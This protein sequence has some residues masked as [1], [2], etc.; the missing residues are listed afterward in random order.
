MK[1]FCGAEINPAPRLPLCEPP[2]RRILRVAFLQVFESHR[3]QIQLRRRDGR[4]AQDAR[5][6]VDVATVADVADREAVSESV[7]ACLPRVQQQVVVMEAAA[8]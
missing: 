7:P 3:P 1:R 4:V 8:R 2:E 5:Q 6:S